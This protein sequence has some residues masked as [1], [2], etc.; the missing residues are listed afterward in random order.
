MSTMVMAKTF[1]DVK[2]TKYEE[3]VDILSD[4]K[5]SDNTQVLSGIEEEVKN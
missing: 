2:N 3:A 4:L 5:G 1:T